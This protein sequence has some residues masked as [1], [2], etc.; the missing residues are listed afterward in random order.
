MKVAPGIAAVAMLLLLPGAGYG[1]ELGDLNCDGA[2]NFFDIEAF[3]LAVTDPAA[4]AATY[5]DCDIM[6]ADCNGDGSVSFFDIDAFVA[7]VTGGP[8]GP[9]CMPDGACEDM[10][11]FACTEDSGLWFGPDGSCDDCYHV[12]INRVTFSADNDVK[13]DCPS[14]S[15]SSYGTPQWLDNNLDGDAEDSGEHEYPVSYTRSEN[16]SLTSVRFGVEPGG[17]YLTGVPV[18]GTGPDG[19]V[20]EGTG[21]VSSGWLNVS[22][23]LVSDIPLPDAVVY[24]GPFEIDWEV[25]LDGENYQVA[26]TSRNRMYVT[27][28]DPM[29]EKLET[30]YDV[31]TKAAQGQTEEQPTIDAIWAEFADLQVDNV[32]G[33]PLAYYRDVLCAGDLSYYTAST[34]VYY[35]TS[36]CGGWADLLMECFRVQGIGGSL[37]ITIEPRGTPYLPLDCSSWPSSASGFLVKNYNFSMGFPG[38][39]PTYP[40]RFNDP[41]DYYAAWGQPDVTDVIGLPGQDNDNPASWFARHFIVKINYKYYDPSYGAGPFEGTTAEACL[42]WEQGGI[43]GYHGMA[44]T[45]SH[46]GVRQ[47]SPLTRECYFN[48]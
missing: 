13:I 15:C 9:C 31:S 47:D 37:F 36:Q 45:S 26:G 12:V 22:G 39:C 46:L 16:V 18:R 10:T 44:D 29:G 30:Y 25:A 43:A 33:E 2:V 24:Y 42:I 7:I 21:T 23:T 14:G 19:L 6:L 48:Q 1:Y 5:P 3:V 41:C 40:W 11:A 38:P 20:F 32:Y 35:T 4:Y 34:L 17:L 27:Y 28:D 8:P